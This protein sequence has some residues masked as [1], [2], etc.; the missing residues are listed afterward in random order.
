MSLSIG[1]LG[2]A[3]DYP[4][5][6]SPNV[7]FKV[8]R[9]AARADLGFSSN[10]LSLVSLPFVGVDIWNAYELSWLNTKGKPQVS[11]GR[12]IVSAQSPY[13]VESKSLKLY[14]NSLNSVRFDSW[15]NVQSCI[16]RDL[17]AL[18]DFPVK[19][20]LIPLEK[21]PLT[22]L[23]SSDAW[24][25]LDELDVSIEPGEP[26]C[27]NLAH[28]QQS[29]VHQIYVSHLF[30]SNC[31]VTHQPDW[32]SV[33]IDYQGQ[34]LDEAALLAYLCAFRNHNGFHEQCVERIFMGIWQTLQPEKL[35]VYARYTRRGGL[36][37]NPWR[38]SYTAQ[39]PQALLR[40]RWV[41][42]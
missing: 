23:H 31:P 37:I 16:E 26:N 27:A 25:C 13:L 38:S 22:L 1:Q 4:S 3:S 12:L 7:L 24:R 34:A 19:F 42:Q 2:L 20:E 5:L 6:Y 28:A 9:L 36:D 17:A 10:T 35:S 39:P 21:E 15:Q 8:S 30:K 14:L 29:Q 11:C 40:D 18:L 32:A 33:W 41:R